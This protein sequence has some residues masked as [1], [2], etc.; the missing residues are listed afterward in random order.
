[1]TD[2]DFEARD[3]VLDRVFIG[4]AT[5]ITT[6]D[7]AQCHGAARQRQYR[8]RKR[9]RSLRHHF[10]VLSRA[11]GCRKE[12]LIYPCPTNYD[13]VTDFLGTLPVDLKAVASYFHEGY[14]V[15]ETAESLGMSKSKIRQTKIRL[16]S[17]I[18]K[19]LTDKQD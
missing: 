10:D 18:D 5:E 16:I 13:P 9:Q 4:G 19:Y 6:H 7:L 3:L 11:A 14:S 12:G 8:R 2:C 17:R 1:M 15:A